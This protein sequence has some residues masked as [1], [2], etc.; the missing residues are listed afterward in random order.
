MRRRKTSRAVGVDGF[1]TEE[2]K[3]KWTAGR[4]SWRKKHP[5]Q[6]GKP[7][8]CPERRLKDAAATA[9]AAAARRMN[10][11]LKNRRSNPE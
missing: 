7:R 6:K 1:G 9:T 5:A 2:R 3:K 10:K 4:T 11:L 8:A